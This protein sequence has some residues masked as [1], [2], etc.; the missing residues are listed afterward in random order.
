MLL[1]TK[2][3]K[4]QIQRRQSEKLTKR[5]IGLYK[6]KK[7]ISTNAIE[8]E[9]PNSIKIHLMVNVSR[10]HRY[11]A[12]V[13]GQKKKWPALVIKTLDHKEN[14]CFNLKPISTLDI[15]IPLYKGSC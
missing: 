15:F 7:I 14:I 1:S 12:Q 4:Y 8:L 2:D 11:K 3:L 5:F 6:V 10:V 9:F 13:N